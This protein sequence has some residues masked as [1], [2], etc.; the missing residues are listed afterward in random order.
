MDTFLGRQPPNKNRV[1]AC[2]FSL[3]G[4][5]M[6]EI[7]FDDNFFC[8]KS[9]LYKLLA[10]ELGQGDI[11]IDLSLP[12]LEPA[13]RC[14]H[15]GRYSSLCVGRSITSM[16]DSWPGQDLIQA[17]FTNLPVPKKNGGRA[18]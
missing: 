15:R 18:Q 10:S 7:R 4:V 5:G 6:N 13:V 11:N 14:K 8:R 17:V 12:G 1:L 16:Q 9:A 2:L 3:P